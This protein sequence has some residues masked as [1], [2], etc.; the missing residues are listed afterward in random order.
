MK[1]LLDKLLNLSTE[2]EVVEIK[3]GKTQY[4]KDRLGKYFSA[5]SNEANLKGQPQAWFVLGIKNDRTIVGTQIS[6]A[7]IN[8]LKNEIAQHTSPRSN[9]GRIDSG[10]CTIFR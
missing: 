8:E 2:N 7:Q 10:F 9:W 6:D 3:E 5:L 1:Q 4:P